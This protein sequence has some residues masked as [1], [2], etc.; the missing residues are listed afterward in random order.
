MV[1]MGSGQT[2]LSATTEVVRAVEPRAAE[3]RALAARA[4]AE[5]AAFFPSGAGGGDV[6]VLLAPRPAA[7]DAFDAHALAHGYARLALTLDSQGVR[8]IAAHL[9]ASPTEETS[10]SP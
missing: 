6:A 9:T 10:T 5:G 7:L 2:L 4:G 8:A 1:A 3:D